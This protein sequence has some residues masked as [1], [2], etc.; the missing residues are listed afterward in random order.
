MIIIYTSRWYVKNSVR[1]SRLR[2]GNSAEVKQR[3]NGRLLGNEGIGFP[4]NPGTPMLH[5][6]GRFTWGK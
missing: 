3:E 6:A 2:L 5:G 1:N 4:E